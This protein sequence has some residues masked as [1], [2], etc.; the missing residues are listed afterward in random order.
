VSDLQTQIVELVRAAG[1]D[2]DIAERLWPAAT[3]PPEELNVRLRRVT[4]SDIPAQLRPDFER[5]YGAEHPLDR[6]VFDVLDADDVR[7]FGRKA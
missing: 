7:V 3:I 6:L 5:F 1:T 4:V 2:D